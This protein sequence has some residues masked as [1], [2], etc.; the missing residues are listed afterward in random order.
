MS[1]FK[2]CDVRGLVGEELTPALFRRMG[3]SLAI[4]MG[5]A[6]RIGVGGDVRPSTP[7]LKAALIEGL[8]ENGRSVTDIGIVPTPVVYFAKRRLKLDAAAMV[9]ASHN[10][11]EYNGLKFMIGDLPVLPEDLERLGRLSGGRESARPN[12]KKEGE[13][14][15]TDVL[16]AYADWL[17]GAVDEIAP[18]RSEP[19]GN[20]RVVVDAGNGC[21]GAVAPGILEGAPGV[22]VVPLFCETDGAFPNR[23]PNSAEP[24]ALAKL[25]ETVRNTGADLG[26]AFDGDGDR[27]AFVD[28]AG[29]PLH[30][31]ETMLLLLRGLA[32]RVAERRVVYDLKC[33]QWVAREAERL[34]ARPLME[35]SGHAFIKRRMIIEE[36]ALGGEASGHYFYD[37]LRG[38]DDGLFTG[39]LMVRLL[40]ADTGTLSE[41]RN[42][43]PK[44]YVTPELRVPVERALSKE[45]L[46]EVESAFGGEQV[47]R[48]D[49][50]RVEFP[51]GWALLRPSITE[52]KVTLRFEGRDATSLHEVMARFLK[53][54]PELSASVRAALAGRR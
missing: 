50:L 48:L 22:E 19:R 2:A 35:R 9:T 31:D 3:R 17:P 23:E 10:P 44:R 26:I 37:A 12:A 7:E 54:V 32:G 53:A 20:R 42:A 49:G 14:V 1:V 18:P 27:V 4:M 29:I 47:I 6:G 21:Y 46:D 43:L 36:A 28:E 15:A 24:E 25:C 33:T 30:A 51:E 34:G 40:Q 45:Y 8:H 16:A 5:D 13:V 41:M 11:A 39:L 52:P 38:G